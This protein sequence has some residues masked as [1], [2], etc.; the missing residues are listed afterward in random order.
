MGSVTGLFGRGMLAA[1]LLAGAATS[2]SAAT[3]YSETFNNPAFAGTAILTNDTSDR[4]GPTNYYTANNA[5]GFTFGADTYFAQDLANLSD[6]ALLINEPSGM[7]STV[8]T[9]L[10]VGMAYDF[11]FLLSGDNRPGEAYVLNVVLNGVT[12]V[13]NG[14]DGASGTNPGITQHIAFTATGTTASLSF[15]QASQTAASPIVDNLL[16]STIASAAP[17]PA[18]WGMLLLGFGIAGSA[19]R[20][21]KAL[22]PA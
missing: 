2:A 18:T 12:T 5:N 11:S 13:F 4:F 19:L 16:V 14:I 20:R 17:E 8:L 1:A 9:G 22:A 7:A 6:F 21:R 15:S 3:V 10:T